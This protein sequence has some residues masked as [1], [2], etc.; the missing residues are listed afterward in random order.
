M[1]LSLPSNEELGV[2]VH[3][4]LVCVEELMSVDSDKETEAPLKSGPD[5]TEK[6]TFP[7]ISFTT[8]IPEISALPDPDRSHENMVG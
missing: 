7:L 2:Y 6:E 4:I 3:I 1:K 5:I 8:N